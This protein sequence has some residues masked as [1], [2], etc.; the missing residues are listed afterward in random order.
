[1][2]LMHTLSMP[3]LYTLS[4]NAVFAS[5][6]H[7]PLDDMNQMQCTS[8]LWSVCIPASFA[9]HLVNLKAYRLYTFLAAND[10]QPGKKKKT[11]GQGAVIIRTILLTV[12]TAVI[13]AIITGIDPPKSTRVIM[14][15]YRAKLDYYVCTSGTTTKGL[16]YLLVIGHVVASIVC[17]MPVRNG[18]EAFQGVYSSSYQSTDTNTH[19]YTHT[20][21]N[22][23][24]YIHALP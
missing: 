22:I 10:S 13:L 5:L 12:V 1:M 7:C 16:F 2:P 4:L 6:S 14:D 3:L 21:S 9:I 8:Y 15:P 24:T 18:F 19:T 20:S 17:I 23:S 11:I